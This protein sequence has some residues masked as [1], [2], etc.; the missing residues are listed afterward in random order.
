MMPLSARVVSRV[1]LA[2][3]ALVATLV[4]CDAATS[5]QPVQ[6]SAPGR[7][8][9][10]AEVLASAT[11]T[12]ST[13]TVQVPTPVQTYP[14]IVNPTWVPIS[15]P[16]PV[17]YTPPPYPTLPPPPAA[18]ALPTQAVALPGATQSGNAIAWGVEREDSLTIWLGTYTDH[19]TPAISD[20]HPVV[21]WDKAQL[22]LDMAA[23]PDGRNLALLTTNVH[24]WGTEGFPPHWLYLVDLN[25]HQ[26]RS[27][28][29]YS[30]TELYSE[31]Y[32]SPPL[33]ILGWLD[34]NRLLIGDGP[35]VATTDGASYSRVVFEQGPTFDIDLS[36]DGTTFFST[37]VSTTEG[38]GLW[39]NNVDGSNAR[40]IFDQNNAKQVAQPVW[41]PDG[42]RIAFLSA[43]SELLPEPT[44]TVV[45]TIH[46]WL[47]D[48]WAV[49][50]Q[51]ISPE[52]IDVWD[53]EPTWSPDGERIAYLRADAPLASEAMP[54]NMPERV[55]T[56]IFVSE[57]G[58][59]AT[60]QLTFFKGIRNSGV[61]WTNGGRIVLSSTWNVGRGDERG[62]I[63]VN[64]ADGTVM[65]LSS[66]S[67]GDTL[68][69]PVIFVR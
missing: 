60:R 19:P 47:L 29:D 3:L 43:K 2:G 6:E 11:A 62:L 67:A 46:L 44:E 37:Q 30:L 7:K 32:Y 14:P 49:T 1:L 65:Q 22:L 50:Y 34:K 40:R 20:A 4:G 61:R 63:A 13:V 57:I 52:N 51:A 69:H 64:V 56:N 18:T 27:I 12:V 66:G 17:P 53:V 8:D 31:F 21:R 41:S 16:T 39:L 9:V 33:R 35:V 55:N 38:Y 54:H 5:F 45:N 23:S 26:V 42:Q 68:V 24:P 58:S 28:P 59:R 25:T 36:P 10:A 15:S 48:P